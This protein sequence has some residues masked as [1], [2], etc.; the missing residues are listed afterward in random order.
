M[1]RYPRNHP[2]T[3]KTKQHQQ[4]KE[5]THQKHENEKYPT[6]QKQ[7]LSSNKKIPPRK[8]RTD[9]EPEEKNYEKERIDTENNKND[10]IKNAHI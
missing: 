6:P 8:R 7:R 2:T 4:D 10:K 9:A 5:E 1:R 3:G